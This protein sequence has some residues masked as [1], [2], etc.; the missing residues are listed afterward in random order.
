MWATLLP[1]ILQYGIP[2][3]EKLWTLISA[4]AA[5]TQAD[6]DNLR[7]LTTQDAK[8]KM[9]EALLKNGIDPTSDAGKSLL[10]LA[11]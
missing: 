3:A 9:L 5:P 7:A 2:V 8:S 6:W 4:N 10:A 11:S 1:V